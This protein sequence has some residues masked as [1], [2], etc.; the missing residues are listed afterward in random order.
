MDVP[1]HTISW[2][3]CTVAVTLP[4]S[5]LLSVP[6]NQSQG[7]R[8]AAYI[9]LFPR[10]VHLWLSAFYV[11]DKIILMVYKTQF[12]NLPLDMSET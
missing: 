4:E 8:N 12:S 2:L 10:L 1:I 11:A 5:L 3:P 6:L 7:G 9:L